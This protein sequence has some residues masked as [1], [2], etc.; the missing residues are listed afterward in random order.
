MENRNKLEAIFDINESNVN[1]LKIPFMS[2]RP[3]RD[4]IISNDEIMNLIINLNTTT[5]IEE[6]LAVL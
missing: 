6:F 5:S 1:S 4:T 3:E 2:G